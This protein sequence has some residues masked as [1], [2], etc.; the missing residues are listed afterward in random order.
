MVT[1]LWLAR[2]FSI[3]DTWCKF[4]VCTSISLTVKAQSAH[5]R[6][7]RLLSR[8]GTCFVSTQL[9][10]TTAQ[11][12]TINKYV[13]PHVHET[14]CLESFYWWLSVCLQPNLYCVITVRNTV[15]F[16]WQFKFVS[17]SLNQNHMINHIMWEVTWACEQSGQ[18]EKASPTMFQSSSSGSKAFSSK[19]F[20]RSYVPNTG[21]MNSFW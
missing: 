3:R 2:I 18:D 8:K 9:G 4:T 15:S 5:H 16:H 1:S 13:N 14:H 11:R 19:K 7:S 21:S 12:G 10:A 6:Q 20:D 17:D